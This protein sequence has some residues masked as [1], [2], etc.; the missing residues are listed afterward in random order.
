MPTATPSQILCFAQKLLGKERT[1]ETERGGSSHE[2]RNRRCQSIGD[3]ARR[4][5]ESPEPVA[6]CDF[7]FAKQFLRMTPIWNGFW[8]SQRVLRRSALALV[9]FGL[10]A[11]AHSQPV[12]AD[13]TGT[14]PDTTENRPRGAVLRSLAV[15][16]W[17]QVY[18]GETYKAPFV[19]G[20]VAGAGVYAYIQQDRYLLYRRAAYYANCL[21]VPGRDVCEGFTSREPEYEEAGGNQFN[22]DAYERVRD[23]ARGNRDLGIVAFVGVYALQVLDAYIAAELADFDVSEDL[24]LG[25][26]PAPGGAAVSLRVGL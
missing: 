15:P 13:S 4:G 2:G 11:S 9:A 18:N 1:T 10:A 7:A 24:S 20:L 21:E 26:V 25:V 8:R 23:T 6:G 5:E 16:S 17:G 3:A 19:V 22:A 12:R 14:Q